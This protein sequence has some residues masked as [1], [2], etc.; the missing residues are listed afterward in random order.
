MLFGINGT[1]KSICNMNI[2]FSK[3]THFEKKLFVYKQI[4]HKY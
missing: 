3:G 4:L 1:I 2:N